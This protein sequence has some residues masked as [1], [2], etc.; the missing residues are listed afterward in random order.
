MAQGF[1]LVCYRIILMDK[2]DK[3]NE[4][5]PLWATGPES[6]NFIMGGGAYEG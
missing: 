6:M 5:G 2:H 3:M 1:V 4:Y